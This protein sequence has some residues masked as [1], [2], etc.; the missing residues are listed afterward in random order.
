MMFN[1]SHDD[2]RVQEISK[3]GEV[4][5]LSQVK[6]QNQTGEKSDRILVLFPAC[7][8]MLSM[9]ERLSSYQYEVRDFD[10]L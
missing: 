8:V 2:C 1:Y 7:L 10:V 3:L 9:S 4:K 5:H 6:M